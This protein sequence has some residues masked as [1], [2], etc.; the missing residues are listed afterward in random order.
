MGS[1]LTKSYKKGAKTKDPSV[2]MDSET[3]CSFVDSMG[4]ECLETSIFELWNYNGDKINKLT[5]D[6]IVDKI[7]RFQEK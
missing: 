6:D 7:N 1:S 2:D 3:Y 5:K 4:T